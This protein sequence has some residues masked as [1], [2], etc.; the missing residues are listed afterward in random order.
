MPSKKA[1]ASPRALH[2]RAIDMTIILIERQQACSL[3]LEDVATALDEPVENLTRLFSDKDAL[4]AA[5]VEQALVILIDTCTRVV[6]RADPNDPVDQFC[7]LGDAY[8]DWA[9]T[10][11]A[12]FRLISD[13]RMVGML[14]RSDLRRYVDSVTD[15]MAR[16][17]TRAQENGQLHPKEDIPL[18]VLS[19]RSFAYGLA[20]MIVDG[21]MAEWVP[22]TPPLETSKRL[23]HD[24]VLRM[25]RSSQPNRAGA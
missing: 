25:A 24:F 3:S 7:A 12:Q 10:H 5:V 8:L 18:M 13:H 1:P 23:A 14:A 9:D 6:V 11:Q 2:E 20:R 15:L 19:A 21:R 4:M 17:L 22:D 16:M